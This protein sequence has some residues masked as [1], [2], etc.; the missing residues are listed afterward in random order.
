MLSR[1]N[2]RAVIGRM[3]PNNRE[4][5]EEPVSVLMQVPDARG[6]RKEMENA[7]TRQFWPHSAGEEV[8][9]RWNAAGDE[10]AVTR[11]ENPRGKYHTASPLKSRIGAG[12]AGELARGPQDAA[13]CSSR[14]TSFRNSGS[15]RRQLRSASLAAQLRLP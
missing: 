10:S 3:P 7:A 9:P 5:E 8:H 4:A 12:S 11:E 13:A 14:P 2:P 6:W 15:S 1:A